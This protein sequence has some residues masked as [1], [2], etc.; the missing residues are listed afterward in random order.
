MTK[1][2][3]LRSLKNFYN[4]LPKGQ[5]S[6]GF[7]RWP[8][9]WPNQWPCPW[10]WRPCPVYCECKRIIQYKNMAPIKNAMY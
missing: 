3:P 9:H 6:I 10:R 5:E 4:I 2:V 1:L 7:V 8:D